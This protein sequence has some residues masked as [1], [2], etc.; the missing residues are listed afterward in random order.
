M[1]TGIPSRNGSTPINASHEPTPTPPLTWLPPPPRIS[2]SGTHLWFLKIALDIL[3]CF[4]CFM[5][6]KCTGHS[7]PFAHW[8]YDGGGG[9]CNR[10]IS[11]LLTH[12]CTRV[13]GSIRTI[14][15]YMSTRERTN[16]HPY[17]RTRVCA[18]IHLGRWGTWTTRRAQASSSG[19]RSAWT[20]GSA[21]R[22]AAPP[23]TLRC[24]R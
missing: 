24:E 15:Q 21:G 8:M 11:R 23:A 1:M 10:A 3:L 22:L 4:E 7:R 19:H 12:N 14:V 18:T 9:V 6:S 13:R 17:N 2:E 5:C 20:D 16:P